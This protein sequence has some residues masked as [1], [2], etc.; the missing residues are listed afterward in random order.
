MQEISRIL[1]SLIIILV[2][3]RFGVLVPLAFVGAYF[4]HKKMVGNAKL[5]S[6]FL[7]KNFEVYSN[8]KA[9]EKCQY[10]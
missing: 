3:N 1:L 7:G 5:C 10:S 9:H 2:I 8:K 4:S 6:L